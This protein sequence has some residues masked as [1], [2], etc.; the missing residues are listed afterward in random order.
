L[1]PKAFFSPVQG[2]R[3]CH[4]A[5][6]GLNRDMSTLIEAESSVDYAAPF[7]FSSSFQQ[8]MKDHIEARGSIGGCAPPP[9]FFNFHY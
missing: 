7:L 3:A 1:K 4:K 6:Q 2:S 9:S 8:K 5:A